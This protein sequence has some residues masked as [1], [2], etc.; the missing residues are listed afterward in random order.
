VCN[1]LTGP[2]DHTWIEVAALPSNATALLPAGLYA[3]HIPDLPILEQAKIGFYAQITNQ[4]TAKL[5][6]HS[7]RI[8]FDWCAEQQIDPMTARTVQLRLYL[9]W[10]QMQGRWAESTVSRLFG[11]VAVFYRQAVIDE[12]I[13][14]DPTLGVKR[15]QVDKAKQHRTWL[16]PLDMARFLKAAEYSGPQVFAMTSLLAECALRAQEA[17][18]LRVEHMQR[19]GGEDRIRFIG[20]GN[21]AAVM[22]LPPAV[23]QAVRDAV[24]TRTQGPV[25][26]NTEGNPYTPN[27][28]WRLMKRLALAADIDP[29]QVSPHTLRRTFARTARQLGE[30]VDRIQSVLR[31]ASPETTMLYIGQQ[32]GMDNIASLQVASFYTAMTA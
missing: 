20:K 6:E 18:S 1:H 29:A 3:G 2:W 21:R 26:L 11:V 4:R 7:L 9:S 30:P 12:L 22:T 10:L 27:S 25:V 23:S 13:L 32:T 28:L 24:G 19:I 31:H 17:C 8:Y 16:V 15:L 14:R 5:Y